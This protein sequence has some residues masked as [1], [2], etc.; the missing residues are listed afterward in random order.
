VN[1]ADVTP[2]DRDGTL[3]QVERLSRSRYWNEARSLIANLHQRA[4]GGPSPDR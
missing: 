4:F 3:Q 2:R 1:F